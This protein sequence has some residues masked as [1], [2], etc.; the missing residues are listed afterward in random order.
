M[1]RD[2]RLY[3]K[4]AQNEPK[5]TQ[6]MIKNQP[7]LFAIMRQGAWVVTPNNRLSN[8]LLQDYHT[9]EN[10]LVT[11]KPHCLPYQAFICALFHQARHQ[12]PYHTHPTVLSAFQQRHLWRL[13]LENQKK[14][15][16]NEG[17]LHEVQD[18]WTRCRHWNIDIEHPAFSHSPQTRQFQ[19]WQQAFQQALTR[20]NA[21]TEE[22][23]VDYALTFLDGFK[24]TPIVWVCFDD[25]TPQQRMLQQAL[26][27]QGSPQHHYDLPSTHHAAVRYTAN[28]EEDEWLEIM[29]WLQSGVTASVSRMGVVVPNL[30]TQFTRL[31]RLLARHLPQ[32]Q[33]NISL[34]KP[35]TDYPLVT[36]ALT[37]LRLDKTWI[38]NHQARLLLLSP[39]LTGSKSEFTARSKTMHTHPLLQE[40]DIPYTHLLQAFSTATPML[41]KVLHQINEYPTQ[42]TPHDWVE[43]F[44]ARLM[45]VGFPGEYPLHS[46]AYQCFQRFLSLFDEL[47][48]LSIL[49]PMMTSEEA[50]DALE[51][52]ATCTIFKTQAST[53]P[54][55]ILGLLEASGCTFDAVWVC[56]LTDQ[57]LP[58]KTNFSAFIPIDLQREQRMPHAV[59]SREFQLAQQL[60]QRLQ[61][62]SQQ[63]VFSYPRLTGDK[64]NMPSPLITHLLERPKTRPSPESSITRLIRLEEDYALPLRVPEQTSGGTT[65]LANQA[66]CPFRAFAAHRLHA[67]EPL[68]L[69]NG[70]DPS[71]R[72]KVLHRVMELLWQELKSQQYLN[73]LSQ[74]ALN[75]HIEQAIQ[76]S[77]A[78]LILKR[79]G[80]FSLLV[81][82][83]ES[84]RLKQ[85]VNACL[86][87]EK[88][89][90][91]FVVEA[92]EQS[93]TIQLDGLDFNV[94]IDRLDRQTCNTKWVID[95]KT[96][97]PITKPWNEDRPEAPQ[98][99]LY[100]LLDEAINTLLY[101]QLKN[102]RITSSGITGDNPLIKGLIPLK[103]GTHWSSQRA[104]WLQQLTHLA[105]E[106]RTGHCPPTPTRNSTCTV[107]EFSTLCRI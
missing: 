27:E 3:P 20:L 30:Q 31:Q 9:Q 48:Q 34:G 78:P 56:D 10:T 84:T 91:P 41:S 107:C 61:D 102:G 85:L 2:D 39:Y 97:I 7:E 36:H 62:G 94:R 87:W 95:Y 93:F 37:C 25:Y 106:F 32:N 82:G 4:G 18:A 92:L 49:C 99:L 51:N 19:E 43:Q 74:E 81:Q 15:P 75:Q 6:R 105:H 54:I 69:A 38:S 8:Q 28:D 14:Y 72:G 24:E 11:D 96:S 104:Q 46:S 35:L 33:F 5:T 59:I 64:P 70:P 13:V 100:A 86:L 68:T 77:L 12:H 90:A 73:T 47:L 101:L 76:L 53:A 79:P 57:C 88:Q 16:C 22:Q 55:Q 40:S 71:E 80:S 65:L 52:A 60:L 45:A 26:A 83:V 89:R 42:A 29:D 63:S 21:I 58:Q 1:G 50:L 67:K 103:K 66:K 44:K 23:I 17:L 98:L